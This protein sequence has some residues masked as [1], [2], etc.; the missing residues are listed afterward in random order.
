M[1]N[2]TN[3]IIEKVDEHIST[4]MEKRAEMFKR[5]GSILD[6]AG[7]IA[8]GTIGSV[9]G[10]TAAARMARGL[11]RYRALAALLGGFGGAAVGGI[12]GAALGQAVADKRRNKEYE[13]LLQAA[14]VNRRKALLDAT[15]MRAF[16]GGYRQPV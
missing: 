9:T 11:G 13:E 10:M 14:E 1:S 7:G 5:A 6:E 4:S 15:A 2:R 16:G 8:G 3:R 12:G